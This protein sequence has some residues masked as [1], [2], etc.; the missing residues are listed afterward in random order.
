MVRSRL[1]RVWVAFAFLYLVLAAVG[2]G[3]IRPGGVWPQANQYLLQVKAWMGEDIVIR[4]E[5]GQRS[6]IEVSPRLDV[7]PY[8]RHREVVDVREDVI[9]ADLACGMPTGDSDRPLRRLRYVKQSSPEG[10][11]QLAEMVCHVG[12]PLGPAVALLPWYVLLRGALATQW[13]GALLGGLAVALMDATM[14]WWLLRFGSPSGLESSDRRMLVTLAGLGTLWLSTASNGG[15]LGM[16]AHITATVGLTAAIALAWDRWWWW[17][18]CALAVAMT[19]RPPTVMAV[20]LLMTILWVRTGRCRRERI[21]AVAMAVMA[22]IMFGIGTLIVNDMRFG[23]PFELGYNYM[24]MPP[25]LL[26]R[27]QSHGLMSPSYLATDFRFLIVQPPVLVRDA[28][29]AVQFPFLVSDTRGMGVIFVTPAFLA[30]ALT[31]RPRWLRRP[32]VTASWISLVLITTPALLHFNTGWVQWGGRFLLDSWPVCLLLTSL[33][34]RGL[35]PKIAWALV[36][37]SILSNVWAVVAV[38]AGRWPP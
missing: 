33:G 27:V 18:G 20:P 36:G 17:S 10:Q 9:V 19:S 13:L 5:H 14:R 25:H 4:G 21:R 24:I 3:G 12:A 31:L 37:L 15:G 8:L 22:P 30:M 1:V 32:L 29:G 23:S 35:R 34:L 6:L 11:R 2:P 38:L 28:S 7:T 26:E 16:F